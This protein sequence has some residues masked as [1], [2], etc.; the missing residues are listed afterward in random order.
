MLGFVCSAVCS[1]ASGVSSRKMRVRNE[2]LLIMFSQ[3]S[4]RF[5]A[6]MRTNVLFAVS[7]QVAP[8]IASATVWN[9]QASIEAG[10]VWPELVA[11]P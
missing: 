11:A 1:V 6:L 5:K 2:G 3:C 9:Y 10:R 4:F 7:K 8:E